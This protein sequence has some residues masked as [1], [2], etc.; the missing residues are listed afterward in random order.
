MV[1]HIIYFQRK[2]QLE[3]KKHMKKHI[4]YLHRH[5]LEL[6]H[7]FDAV[8]FSPL[9]PAEMV[10]AKIDGGVVKTESYVGLTWNKAYSVFFFF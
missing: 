10:I 5:I 9:A 2:L 7:D 4:Y 8:T 3:L 6:Q 1:P